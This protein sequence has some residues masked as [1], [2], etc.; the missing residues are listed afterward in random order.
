MVGALL[1]C[2]LPGAMI[3][4]TA[5]RVAVSKCVLNESLTLLGRKTPGKFHYFALNSAISSCNEYLIL[6][7]SRKDSRLLC[8]LW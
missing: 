3:P 8:F 6:F 1:G 2:E 5:E 7:C 4:G